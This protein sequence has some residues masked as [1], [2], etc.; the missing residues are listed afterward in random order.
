MAFA[1]VS[2]PVRDVTG[3]TFARKFITLGKVITYWADAVGSD[4]AKRSYPVG[5]RVR[6]NGKGPGVKSSR[7]LV[8]TLEIAASSADAT[9]L[10]YQKDLI[11]ERLGLLIGAD[12]IVDIKITHNSSAV[13]ARPAEPAFDMANWTPQTAVNMDGMGKISPA[14]GGDEDTALQA[15]LNR[16]ERWIVV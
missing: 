1:H 12:M 9:L 10:H 4:L 2:R 13:L 8:A 3:K 6:K 14:A 16:L 11:L 5:M 7:D 15:A